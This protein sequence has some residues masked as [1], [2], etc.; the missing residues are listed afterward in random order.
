MFN[1]PVNLRKFHPR[2]SDE[3]Y[4]KDP[5]FILRKTLRNVIE[6]RQDQY[7]SM[8]KL[9][10]LSPFGNLSHG[11]FFSVD[12]F[13]RGRRPMNITGAVARDPRFRYTKTVLF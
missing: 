6:L 11:V 1:G 3:S 12:L 4:S 9:S 13:F 10:N 8:R 2:K 7:T 5:Y